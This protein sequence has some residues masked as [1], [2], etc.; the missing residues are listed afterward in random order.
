VTPVIRAAVADDR[1]RV[2]AL[3]ERLAAF[4][5]PPWRPPD[6]I[7]EGERRTLRRFFDGGGPATS[8]LLVAEQDGSVAGFAYLE[9]L[10]D[11]FTL[12]HH[13][14]VGI[15]AVAQEAEGRGVGA[16][17]LR[18]AESWGLSRR[19]RMLTLSVFEENARARRIYE[20]FGFQTDTIR[21]LKPL[22]PTGR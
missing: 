8:T 6:D 3:A 13:G 5:P 14:H 12:E 10:Q 18:A 4:G 19:Y 20:R 17:L 11:Y 16:A 9:Q 7:T 22:G 2:L 21:Y 15:L 1:E